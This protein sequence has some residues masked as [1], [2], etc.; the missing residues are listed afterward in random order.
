MTNANDMSR[1][2][3]SSSKTSRKK[4]KRI[5][6]T[7]ESARDEGPRLLPLGD[8]ISEPSKLEHYLD[9]ADAALGLKSEEESP[10][11]RANSQQE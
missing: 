10:R 6:P 1:R 2:T 4:V 11:P 7:A 8:R 9:L 3:P 5:P